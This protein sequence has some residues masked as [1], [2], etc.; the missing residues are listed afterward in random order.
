MKVYETE[1]VIKSVDSLKI[2]QQ[3]FV[4][5]EIMKMITFPTGTFPTPV[6]IVNLFDRST[7]GAL[8]YS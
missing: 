2:R 6:L 5:N 8:A 7:N 3:Q 4:T 1:C